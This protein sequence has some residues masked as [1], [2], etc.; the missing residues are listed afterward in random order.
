MKLFKNVNLFLLVCTILLV[1]HFSEAYGFQEQKIDSLQYYIELASNPKDETNLAKAYLFFDHRKKESIANNNKAFT[2][3]YLQKIS[4][5]QYHLGDYYG[6]ENSVVSALTL[7]S[8]STS[9]K[10]IKSKLGLYNLLGKIYGE[11]L[12]YN[13]A[14]KYYNKGLK[15]ALKQEYINIIQNNIALIYI[16]QNKFELAEQAFLEIYNNSIHLDDKIQ[17]YRALDNLGFVQSKLNNPQGLTNMLE[18]LDLKL[19]INHHM[20]VYASYG[21]LSKYYADINNLEQAR[22]YA[23]KGYEMAKIINSP[24]FIKDALTNL[25]TL[26]D[27]TNALEYIK[28]TDSLFVNKQL[29]ENKYAK[30]KYDYT[31]KENLAKENE[32]Q[33]EREKRWKLTYLSIGIFVALMSVFFLIFQKLK[34]RKEKILQIYNTEIRISKKIHDEV[35]N[36]VHRVINKLQFQSNV[37]EAIIEDLD[38][39][40]A[41][42]RDISKENGNLDVDNNFDALLNDLFLNYKNSDVN[43]ITRNASEI[44]W[45]KVDNYKKVTIF[46]VIQELLVNMKK[47]SNAS[48]VVF[49][50]SKIKKKIEVAYSDNGIGCEIKKGSGIQNMETRIK[51]TKGTVIF[52]AEPN[53]GFKAKITI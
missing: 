33:S 21:H 47:H 14:L 7:L 44:D 28:I 29:E 30:V 49:K 31:E 8:N 53:K 43:I 9:P 20:S 16:K 27:D 51:S 52:E 18:A 32:L 40:Y 25:I 48:L 10:D 26:E 4:R 34:Y 1:S 37:S 2:V 36:D 35:A 42:T 45:N 3:Y 17:T 22:F 41:R 11:L 6:S 38:H 50:F 13:S 5:I 23:E 46:R 39:I 15:I 24:T 19:A 12:D